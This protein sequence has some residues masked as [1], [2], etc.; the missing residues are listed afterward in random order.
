MTIEELQQQIIDMQEQVTQL[1]IT[2][3]E[4]KKTNDNQ[5]TK[6]NDL[7]TINQQLF[8]KVTSPTEEEQT[9]DTE[10]EYSDF[11]GKNLW[12]KLSNVDKNKLITILEGED[13]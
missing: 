12:D 2:N 11:V 13:E 9:E 5:Q 1:N 4:L 8:L 10:K 6:I 7:T 3:E